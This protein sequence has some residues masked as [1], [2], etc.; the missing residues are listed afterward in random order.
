[1]DSQS[2]YREKCRAGSLML[3]RN[4]QPVRVSD[5]AFSCARDRESLAA[6]LGSAALSNWTESHHV[7]DHSRHPGHRRACG[8]HLHPRPR[9]SRP[10][11]KHGT[12]PPEPSLPAWV[13]RRPPSGPAAL[14]DGVSYPDYES[15]SSEYGS[16][17]LRSLD[18]AP[19]AN[20]R[21]PSHDYPAT[22]GELG[23][24]ARLR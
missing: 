20:A 13:Y 8:F 4:G 15:C 17:I 14:E 24:Y 23:P 9:R 12:N 18:A 3:G 2:A 19:C 5:T 16:I 10:H 21:C 7:V 22:H 6:A 1:M 11:L